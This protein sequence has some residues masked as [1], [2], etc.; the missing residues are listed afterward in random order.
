[1]SLSTHALREKRG[2]AQDKMKAITKSDNFDDGKRK[3][4]DECETEVRNLNADIRRMELVEKAE[5]LEQ[6]EPIEGR[7]H[8][9]SDL[10][11]RFNVGK[12]IF[13]H[14]NGQLTG[15]EAEYH[16]ERRSG[17]KDSLSIP[18]S[19]VLGERRALTKTTPAGGPGSNLVQTSLGPYIDALRP[20]LAVEAMGATILPGLTDN[21]DLPRLKASGTAGWVAEHTDGTVTDPQFD[22]V[23]MSPK[24]VTAQYEVSRRMLLQAANLDPILR[25]DLGYLLAQAIDGAAI[26]GGGANQPSGILANANVSVLSLGANGAAMTVDTAADLMGLV[27]DANA[28]GNLGFLTNS[29]VKKA[30]AKLKDLQSRPYG[31]AEVFKQ[32]PLTFTNQVPSNL[33]KGTSGAV[34]SAI[35]FGVWSDLVVAYWSSIDIVVNP[36]AD[37]VAKKGGAFIHAFLDADIGI[38][39]PLSFA[40]AKDVLA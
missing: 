28:F 7:G 19:A 27:D 30:A 39:Q 24:T 3:E 9:L 8:D 10:E 5:R 20:V 33:V 35:I 2:L 25:G 15:V 29:K 38:R 34:C 21:I 23:A 31:L 1:M 22:K 32:S 16:A 11:R 14:V 17:R 12:A 6:A 13:E 40:V 18:V 26:A 4:F 37:S 36:Y